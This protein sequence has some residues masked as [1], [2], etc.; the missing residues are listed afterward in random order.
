MQ[1]SCGPNE[2]ET[3]VT[4]QGSGFTDDS[5][6]LHLKWGTESRLVESD[7]D[8]IIKGYSAPTSTNNTH[9]GFIYVEI[10]HN[11]ELEDT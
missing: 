6:N 10:G 4:I 7:A 5:N 3:L 11:R 1:P 9:G 2:G 8:D